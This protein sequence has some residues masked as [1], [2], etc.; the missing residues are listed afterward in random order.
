L[1][2]RMRSIVLGAFLCMITSYKRPL[3]KMNVNVIVKFRTAYD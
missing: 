3:L 2:E 1:P